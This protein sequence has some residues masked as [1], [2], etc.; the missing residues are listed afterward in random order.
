MLELEW[1][2]KHWTRGTRQ[3]QNQ[4]WWEVARMEALKPKVKRWW[5][6][7]D[8]VIHWNTDILDSASTCSVSLSEE[9]STAVL[10]W[11]SGVVWVLCD[12]TALFPSGPLSHWL[13]DIVRFSLFE[14]TQLSTMNC[15]S[16]PQRA[17][18]SQLYSSV[19]LQVNFWLEIKKRY[20][21]ECSQLRSATAPLPLSGLGHATL[22]ERSAI[23]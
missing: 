7:V 6:K 16:L 22:A 11:T 5:G 18:S 8:A 3:T 14:Y 4:Q 12:R 23:L 17:E 2:W 15:S 9:P 21:Q 1:P 19:W 20:L 13:V 10:L